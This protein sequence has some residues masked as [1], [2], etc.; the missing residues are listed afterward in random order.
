MNNKK[1]GFSFLSLFEHLSVQDKVNFA[2]HLGMIVKAGLPLN[3]GLSIIK[4]QSESKLIITIIEH[5]QRDINNGKF[6][7]DSLEYYHNVFGDF[8]INI[9]RVGESSGT[10]GQ[11][12]FYLADE[13]KKSKALSGKVRSAMIYPII[14]FIATVGLTSFLAF[15]I[16]PKLLP[17]FVSLKVELPLTTR[18]LIQTV[19]F[20]RDYVLIVFV[21]LIS[22]VVGVRILLS[23]FE[24]FQIIIDKFV[25]MLPVISRVIID[26]QMANFT[27]ILGLLLK[28]G[29]NIVEAITVTA[30]T[31]DHAVYKKALFEAQEQIKKGEQLA[32][33][34]SERKDLF[35][36][37]VSG[38]VKIGENTGNLEENLFYLADYYTEE[39]DSTLHDLTSFLEPLMLLLMG[40]I[41]GFVALSIITPIYSISQNIK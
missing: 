30:R 4:K 13:L 31:F 23:R 38:M 34:L 35:P 33:Y 24:L 9:I 12:L 7:A 16:F 29:L 19:N 40:L 14:I 26:V 3:E 2:R 37:L 41:I 18:I 6:L 1:R 8:F 15:G 10:L 21:S 25:L 28:G 27:R 5:I 22:F 32:H 11:N 17:I 36:P 39:V 20:L